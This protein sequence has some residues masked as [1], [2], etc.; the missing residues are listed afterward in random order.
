[1]RLLVYTRSS[2]ICV[3]P[4]KE[5][6][7]YKLANSSP[8]EPLCIYILL[9]RAYLLPGVCMDDFEM[10]SFIG[11]KI[12][13]I[14]VV[15]FSRINCSWISKYIFIFNRFH[16]LQCWDYYNFDRLD[17]LFNVW[18][19][20]ESIQRFSSNLHWPPTMDIWRWLDRLKHY[21]T[22]YA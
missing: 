11:S 12:Y 15:H 21:K 17:N 2:D 13:R 22:N 9:L 16:F 18:L 4:Y 10:L 19:F 1:M 20:K 8:V 3:S 5:I 6:N 14:N 7:E